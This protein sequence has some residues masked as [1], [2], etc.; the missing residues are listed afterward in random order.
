MLHGNIVYGTWKRGE[1]IYKDKNGYYI[2]QY[3]IN[4]KIE[5]KKYLKKWKPKNNENLLYLDKN[6]KKW[7]LKKQSKK[8]I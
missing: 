6:K 1:D 3:D 4:K 2:I 8:T 7:S 5:Y